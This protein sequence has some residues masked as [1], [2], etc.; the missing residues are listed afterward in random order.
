MCNTSKTK[1]SDFLVKY[2]IRYNSNPPSKLYDVNELEQIFIESLFSKF[3]ESKLN[4]SLRMVRMS[5]GTL[6]VD[7]SG[8]PI[9]KVKL[10]GR[11]HTMQ[12]LKGL[13][14]HS[15]VEGVIEDF[16][17]KIDAWVKYVKRYIK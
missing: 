7:Y 9:G 6:A 2:D 3:Q 10:Q 16:I 8:Y 5:D 1:G 14:T 12:I 4:G 11:I 17:P 13:Y 15:S